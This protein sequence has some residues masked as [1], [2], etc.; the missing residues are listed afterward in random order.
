VE[1]TYTKQFGGTGL[2]LAISQ[3]LVNL[4]GG[5]IWV[6]SDIGEGTS[7]YFTAKFGVAPVSSILEDSNDSLEME[8]EAQPS[9]SEME[10]V[11]SRRKRPKSQS[12]PV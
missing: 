4:M 12:E 3:R 9:S 2:G 11:F 10:S 6:E 8:M 7:F 5:T 1:N